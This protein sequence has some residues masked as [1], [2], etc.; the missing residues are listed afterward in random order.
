MGG[1]EGQKV[2]ACCRPWGFKELD[3]TGRLNNSNE[4]KMILVLVERRI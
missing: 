3:K 2:L 4:S 1:G